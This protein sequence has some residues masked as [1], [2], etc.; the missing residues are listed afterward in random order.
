[1]MR[2]HSKRLRLP[3]MLFQQINSIALARRLAKGTIVGFI[4][5]VTLWSLNQ[6]VSRSVETVNLDFNGAITAACMFVLYLPARMSVNSNT[7]IPE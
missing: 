3:H 6:V 7:K 2:P 4:P 1:M 5:L